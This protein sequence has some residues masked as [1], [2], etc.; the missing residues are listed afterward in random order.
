MHNMHS[1][2][3]Q[4]HRGEE[5]QLP[6]SIC[7]KRGSTNTIFWF[8]Y[9]ECQTLEDAFQEQFSNKFYNDDQFVQ[10]Q[11]EF[12]H[13]LDLARKGMLEGIRQ[14]QLI[15]PATTEPEIIYEIKTHYPNSQRSSKRTGYIGAR[16]FHG[17]DE[18]KP[19]GVICVYLYAKVDQGKEDAHI[20]Q[21]E[22]A[23]SAAFRFDECRRS[24][25]EKLVE[26]PPS[27]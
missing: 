6:E 4:T 1:S 12:E 19:N 21:D 20:N 26:V 3:A 16:L 2:G 11:V 9:G 5:D 10:A 18:S 15:N 7:S 23:K 27:V 24:R 8:P 22:A 14:I 13:T 17:Q 25:W